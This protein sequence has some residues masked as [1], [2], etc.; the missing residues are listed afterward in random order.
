MRLFYAA[1][2]FSKLF[3]GEAQLPVEAALV[4]CTGAP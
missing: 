1:L 4:A 2:P 3:L